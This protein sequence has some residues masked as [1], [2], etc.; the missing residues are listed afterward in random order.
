MGG[1][2]R[3]EGGFSR[4][5]EPA[6]LETGRSSSLSCT[7][8][9]TSFSSGTLSGDPLATLSTKNTNHSPAHPPTPRRTATNKPSSPSPEGALPL[10]PILVM[11]LGGLGAILLAGHPTYALG[12]V[13][14]KLDLRTIF[15]AVVFVIIVL[16]LGAYLPSRY[17]HSSF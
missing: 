8:P 6:A 1:K 13:F 10:F 16:V 9:T 7:S 5:P 4:L 17:P 15:F 3:W 14:S 12:H 11:A 2:R